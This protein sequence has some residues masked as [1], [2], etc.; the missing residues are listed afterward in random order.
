MAASLT[1]A[2]STVIFALRPHPE[3]A[4]PALWLPLVRRIRSP[5][6]G[7]WALPGGPL[8]PAEDLA[9]SAA[10]NL[11]E[12]THLAPRYLEQLYAFGRP[13]RSDD[14]TVSIV[15][16]ALVHADEASAGLETEN[17]RWFLADALPPLAFDH[18][19]IVEYALWRLRNK[20][21]YSRIAAAFL[22]ETFTLSELREVHEVVLERD[23]DPANFRRQVESTGLVV[24]T[25][26]FRTGGRHRPARLY[27]HDHSIELADNGP[28]SGR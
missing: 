18:S 3:T 13:D 16:W 6:K 12:T 23:L 2:V 25:D 15:Y 9:A 28:L 7:L 21:E 17:V 19:L 22:G 4:H 1:L 10:R 8:G 20:M 14:R 11:R 24:P 5:H 26:E 27:R